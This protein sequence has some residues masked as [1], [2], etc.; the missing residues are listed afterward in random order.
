MMH[1]LHRL[2]CPVLAIVLSLALVARGQAYPKPS[3]YPVAWELKFEHSLPKRIVMQTDGSN[4]PQ[5]FWYMTYTVTNETGQEQLFLPHFELVTKEG[6]IV[7][8]D[9]S[10][11]K[12]VFDRVKQLEGNRFLTN[13]ALIGGQ[14]RLGPDEAKD[15]VAI[16]Q[17]P[18]ADMGNFQVYISGISGESA[19]VKGADGKDG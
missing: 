1:N 16:W 18:D 17:E 3:V 12:S 19:K 4:V 14:L 11:P 6:R 9:K 7:R 10:I 13:A 15:G 5:A 2:F 8:S